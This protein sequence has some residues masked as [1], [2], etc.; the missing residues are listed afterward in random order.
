MSLNLVKEKRENC[1]PVRGY[2]QFAGTVSQVC[3]LHHQPKMN[4][5]NSGHGFLTGLTQRKGRMSRF[6]IKTLL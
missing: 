3:M 2:S 1:Y 6:F 4:K 5:T